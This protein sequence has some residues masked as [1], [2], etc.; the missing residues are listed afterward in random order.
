MERRP[1]AF[2]PVSPTTAWQAARDFLSSA[3]RTYNQFQAC[4]QQMPDQDI[5]LEGRE[6][7]KREETKTWNRRQWAGPMHTYDR[8]DTPN[9]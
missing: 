7:K 5:L 8:C 3:G 4:V 1:Y 9:M 2:A 6:K